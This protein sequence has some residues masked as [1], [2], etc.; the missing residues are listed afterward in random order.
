MNEEQTPL[1]LLWEITNLVFGTDFPRKKSTR[2][3]EEV[4]VRHVFWTVA[5]EELGYSY[6]QLAAWNYVYHHT[7]VLHGLKRVRKAQSLT[8]LRLP[9]EPDVAAA[10]FQVRKIFTE[11]TQLGTTIITI[12]KYPTLA[13]L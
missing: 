6:A 7:S 4:K 8:P 10:Y 3:Q 11:E 9:S 2:K 5:A 13:Y 12:P 1:E